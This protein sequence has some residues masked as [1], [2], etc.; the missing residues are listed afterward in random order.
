MVNNST[1]I[2]RFHLE[3]SLDR[4]RSLG[5]SFW[6]NVCRFIK[7]K[8]VDFNAKKLKSLNFVALELIF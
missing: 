1:Q 5:K 6:L 2:T 3:K 7:G 4:F 8:E